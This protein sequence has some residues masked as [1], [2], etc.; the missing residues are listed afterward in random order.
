MGI[1]SVLHNVR[2]MGIEGEIMAKIW[3][4]RGPG[5]EPGGKSARRICST[6]APE[7]LFYES[8][9]GRDDGAGVMKWIL[10]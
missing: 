1:V 6:A 9:K 4:R 2:L 7:Q 5:E 3:E 8:G 10:R